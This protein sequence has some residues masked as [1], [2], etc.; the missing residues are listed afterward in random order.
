MWI[1]IELKNGIIHN[2]NTNSYRDI[3][4]KNTSLCFVKDFR[5]HGDDLIVEVWFSDIVK[6][7]SGAYEYSG[8]EINKNSV[9]N[10]L[11]HVLY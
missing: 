8:S 3:V 10:L 5:I 2:L 11:C 7:K 9:H 4:I 1:K 6:I